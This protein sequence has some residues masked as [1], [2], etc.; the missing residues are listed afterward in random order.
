MHPDQQHEKLSIKIDFDFARF[1][2]FVCLTD[3]SAIYYKQ[4]HAI[5]QGQRHEVIRNTYATCAWSLEG[6]TSLAMVL[7]IAFLVSSTRYGYGYA[8]HG[9]KMHRVNHN[10]E[11]HNLAI[12]SAGLGRG[13]LYR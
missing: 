6:H 5:S 11:H 9:H 13:D 10:L 2:R 8:D 12:K 4:N 7:A 3:F 1:H